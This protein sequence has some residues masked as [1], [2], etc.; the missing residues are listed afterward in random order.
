VAL[1]DRSVDAAATAGSSAGLREELDGIAELIARSAEAARSGEALR[2]NYQGT[3]DN[4]ARAERDMVE[5]RA[6]LDA[7]PPPVA[8]EGESGADIADAI[9]ILTASVDDRGA[10]LCVAKDAARKTEAALSLGA[11][12]RCPTCMQP[13]TEDHR[14]ALADELSE[15][16][17]A[18]ELY[19]SALADTHALLAAARADERALAAEER[20]SCDHA[21]AAQAVADATDRLAQWR[22]TLDATPEPSCEAMTAPQI[23]ALR[24]RKAE[25]M[26]QLAACER[27]EAAASVAADSTDDARTHAVRHDAA[28]SLRGLIETDLRSASAAAAAASVEDKINRALSGGMMFRFALAAAGAREICD[29][30]VDVQDGHGFRSLVALSGGEKAAALAA[31]G[32]ALVADS[33]LRVVV[34]DELGRM[35]SVDREELLAALSA[36]VD[37]G[38]LD[39][40]IVTALP[41]DRPPVDAAWTVVEL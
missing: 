23:A 4:A 1:A 3:A 7:M 33:P 9:E 11:D 18:I 2:A 34:V 27:L 30:E 40:I 21:R 13:V 32:T 17:D 19:T 39:Q 24:E 14:A 10:R 20:R 12:A 22:A 15:Q 37:R 28:K 16:R 35:E 29:P 25:L 5:A 6:A 38:E 41:E 26:R 36:S 31:F 8:R